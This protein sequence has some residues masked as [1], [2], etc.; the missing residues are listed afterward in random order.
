MIPIVPNLRSILRLPLL[1]GAVLTL[2]AAVAEADGSVTFT[3]DG[4]LGDSAVEGLQ[5]ELQCRLVPDNELLTTSNAWLPRNGTTV[6]EATVPP[7]GEAVCFVSAEAPPGLAVRY[8]GDGGS[9]ADID[10]GACRFSKVQP[11][12][13][14]FCQIQGHSRDTSITVFKKW[15]GARDREPDVRIELV[16]DGKRMPE[17]RDVNSGQPAA[18]SLDVTNPDGIVCSVIEGER[19]DFVP[20][21]SECRDLLILPA[22]QEECTLVNTKIVKMIEMLNRY[23]L[24]IMILVFMA[25]GMVAARRF[26]P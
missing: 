12:H 13:A 16:C 20:D 2:L 14:N 6:F 25:V 1:V 21:A 7:G 10:E 11:G 22:S 3:V 18:W 23:G 8:S 4:H 19:E 9:V 26:V 15:I 17:A 5:V 24:A